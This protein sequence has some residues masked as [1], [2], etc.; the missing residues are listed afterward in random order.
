MHFCGNVQQIG[1]GHASYKMATNRPTWLL[2]DDLPGIPRDQFR[3]AITEAFARWARV[4]DWVARETTDKLANILITVVDL[5]GPGQVL[6]DMQLP[7]PG[8][9]QQ[10]MRVDSR[11]KW[12]LSDA[13]NVQG[14]DLVRVLCHELG[15]AAGLVHLS[16][17]PPPD[18]MEP[19]YSATVIGPQAAEAKLMASMYGPPRVAPAPQ[20]PTANARWDFRVMA[21]GNAQVFRDGVR[22]SIAPSLFAGSP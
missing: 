18:L 17:S 20:P 19:T 3:A 8:L 5:G 14:I 21:D 1:D 7:Q 10:V 12:V 4:S 13:A 2:R 22:Q 9:R 6:A 11:E 15:H 16:P